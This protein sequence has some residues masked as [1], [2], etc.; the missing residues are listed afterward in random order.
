MEEPNK[1]VP[2]AQ[3]DQ[4]DPYEGLSDRAIRRL[5]LMKK[6]RVLADAVPLS[7]DGNM[8]NQYEYVEASA[9]YESLRQLLIRHGIAFYVSHTGMVETENKSHWMANFRFGLQDTETGYEEY[10]DWAAEVRKA[11]KADK[12]IAAVTTMCVKYYLISTFLVPTTDLDDVDYDNEEYSSNNNSEKSTTAK[13]RSDSST[14]SKSKKTQAKKTQPSSTG[15]KEK[16][17]TATKDKSLKLELQNAVSDA[18]YLETSDD[19][20]ARDNMIELMSDAMGV[21]VGE[22][23]WDSHDHDRLM[24]FVS[25]LSE[26]KKM[27]IVLL[28]GFD[29]T[30]TRPS[31]LKH[32]ERCRYYDKPFKVAMK[33]TQMYGDFLTEM[34]ELGINNLLELRERMEH[35]KIFDE[36]TPGMSDTIASKIKGCMAEDQIPFEA[37]DDVEEVAEQSSPLDTLDDEEFDD[38]PA[39]AQ[40]VV[41]D[42]EEEEDSDFDVE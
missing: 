4:L 1:F 19:E 34:R 7:K 25:L 23:K 41:D 10:S 24:E 8:N 29:Y 28:G 18:G 30:V 9:A 26:M 3:N 16:T 32:L 11:S 31:V 12:Q 5:F 42:S 36:W 17:G 13:K 14:P 33:V 22:Y 40:S 27:G 39:P 2:P 20:T 15:K 6:A 37:G 38:I 35:A 21:G